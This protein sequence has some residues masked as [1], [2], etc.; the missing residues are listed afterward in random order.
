[1]KEV[2]AVIRANKIGDTK[3]ALVNE[4]FPAFNAV[5]VL[6]RGRQAIEAEVIDALNQHPDDAN[7]VLPLLAR[8]P[9]LIPKRL[10]S[11]VVPDEQ[12][13]QVVNTIT[14]VNQTGNPGDGKIFVVP[15]TDSIRIRTA[16]SGNVAVDEMTGVL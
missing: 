16:E 5:K 11:V 15:V 9:R 14:R 13:R 7:E 4:G 8:C 6:G 12:V 2:M 10:V 1:M 3:Q